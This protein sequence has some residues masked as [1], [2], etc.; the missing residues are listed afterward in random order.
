[1]PVADEETRPFWSGLRLHALVIARCR[2]CLLWMHPPT[3]SCPRCH[4]PDIG[5]DPVSG[6]G[7][8]YSYT[9]VHRE[10]I[11]GVPPPYVVVLVELDE[12]AGLR[13]LAN[14]IE[15][16]RIAPRIDL[17]VEARFEDVNGELTLLR[18]APV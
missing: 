1:M 5:A 16:D 14:L 13:V 2:S 10:F 11:A 15:T 17:P 3:A 4:S 9:T 8:V 18:F 7:R 6:R 12:Q